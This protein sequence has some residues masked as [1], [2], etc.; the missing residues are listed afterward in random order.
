MFLPLVLQAW[1]ALDLGAESLKIGRESSVGLSL[2]LL[3]ST[4]A[5]DL[6]K[7]GHEGEKWVVV[8]YQKLRPYKQALCKHIS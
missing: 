1:G 8:G 4:E 3:E 7:E 5:L 6:L 2:S